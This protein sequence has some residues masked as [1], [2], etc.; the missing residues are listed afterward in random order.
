MK[1]RGFRVELSEVE[2]VIRD[3]KDIKDAT[4]KDFTDPSGVKYIVAY[5]VSDKKINVEEL[6]NFI[7]EQKP[8]YMVPA[9]TMQIDKIPLNQNQKVNKRALPVPELKVEEMVAPRNSDEQ[10][11]FD[12]LK[13]VLG[14]DQFGVTND[15]FEVGL[16]SVSSIRFTILLSKKYNKSV[17]NG[18]LKAHST[19]ASL[20]EFLANK[21]EDKT[22]EVLD[23]YPLTKTQEGIFVECVS[24]P[25]STN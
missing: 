1:I 24:K 22:F 15:I 20:A 14:H 23:E 16:T 8:P 3:F 11:I 2:K 7:L 18:D 13:G 6:N 17:D 4:V 10:D 21:E 9:Y 12:I 19:I 5:V 25:N